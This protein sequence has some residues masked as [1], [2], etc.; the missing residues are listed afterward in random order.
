MKRKIICIAFWAI[1]KWMTRIYD[2]NSGGGLLISKNT[3]PNIVFGP[4]AILFEYEFEKTIVKGVWWVVILFSSENSFSWLF[5]VSFSFS[6]SVSISITTTVFSPE[7]RTE[8]SIGCPIK[9]NNTAI[10]SKV[11]W[12]FMKENVLNFISVCV[13]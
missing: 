10:L 12:A 8:L 3:E 2:S 9:N 5:L 4:W 7:I 1:Q 13:S 11:L 6:D